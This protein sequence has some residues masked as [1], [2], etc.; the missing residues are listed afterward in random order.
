MNELKI[1]DIKTMWVLIP[2][3]VVDGKIVYKK[4][5]V[6]KIIEKSYRFGPN[7]DLLAMYADFVHD[8]N[9]GLITIES[10]S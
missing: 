3:K 9:E 10:I 6:N 8:K 5:R 1:E 4:C 7:E 2:C